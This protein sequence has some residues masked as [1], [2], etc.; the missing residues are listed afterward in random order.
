MSQGQGQGQAIIRWETPPPVTRRPATRDGMT[1]VERVRQMAAELRARPGEWGVV[2]EG[3]NARAHVT[4]IREG[5]VLAWR[6]A[7]AFEAAARTVDG[8]IT[9]YARYVGTAQ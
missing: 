6:P 8:R 1:P 4:R 3:N 5:A 7:G 2:A 9:I